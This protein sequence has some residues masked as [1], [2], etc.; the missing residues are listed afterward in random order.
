M[1]YITKFELTVFNR[2][3]EVIFQSNDIFD[4]WDGFSKR[5]NQKAPT[6]VYAYRILY[7]D[8]SGL[9]KDIVGSVHLI[10]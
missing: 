1:S 6:G 7:T 9:T 4:Q 3:G 8:L 2:W 5:T 10:R